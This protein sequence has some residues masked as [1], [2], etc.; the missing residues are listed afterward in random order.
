MESPERQPSNESV[1]SQKSASHAGLADGSASASRPSR[2]GEITSE[3]ARPARSSMSTPP[4]TWRNSL[5]PP[6]GPPGR[7]APLQVTPAT[8]T[9]DV[10][11][12]SLQPSDAD[13]TSARSSTFSDRERKRTSFSSLYSLGLGTGAPGGTRGHSAASSVAGSDY[14]GSRSDGQLETTSLSTSPGQTGIMGN[15]AGSPPATSATEMMEPPNP[16]RS[17]GSWPSQRATTPNRQSRSRHP[18]IRRPSGCEC[19]IE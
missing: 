16:P 4:T 5:Q 8:T 12:D 19:S 14:E 18:T 6:R 3:T 7:S 2:N 15:Q 10:S 13:V 1:T 9:R 11:A 17:A